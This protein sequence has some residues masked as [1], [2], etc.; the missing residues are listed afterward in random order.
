MN[1][2]HLKLNKLTAYLY[3]LFILPK[4]QAR[5]ENTRLLKVLIYCKY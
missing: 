1:N 4:C 2:M 5:T 3:S